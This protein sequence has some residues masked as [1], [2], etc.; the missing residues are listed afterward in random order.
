MLHSI[1]QRSRSRQQPPPRGADH[2][3]GAAPPRMRGSRRPQESGAVATFSR[4]AAYPEKNGQEGAQMRLKAQERAEAL[5]VI[6]E[7]WPDLD[8]NSVMCVL[9]FARDCWK[10]SRQKAA[11]EA[12]ET[13]TETAAE[14]G[15]I[16][17]FPHR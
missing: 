16:I 9:R 13:V 11:G 7:Y 8:D 10:L 17:P 6:A 14:S 2:G 4:C 5:E 15:N 3:S 1:Q 12:A